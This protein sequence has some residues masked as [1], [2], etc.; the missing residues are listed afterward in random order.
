MDPLCSLL[1][2]Q[3]AARLVAELRVEEPRVAELVVVR[4]LFGWFR[5]VTALQKGSIAQCWRAIWRE[6]RRRSNRRRSRQRPRQL[7]RA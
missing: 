6:V 2:G 5:G 3:V 1:V 4:L 7:G